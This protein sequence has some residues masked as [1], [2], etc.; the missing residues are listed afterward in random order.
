MQYRVHGTASSRL[1]LISSPQERH[2]PK[3]PSRTRL[4]ASSTSWSNCFSFVL[5][6]NKKS[7]V[8]VLAARSIT[9]GAT[10]SSM[11]RPDCCFWV[12]LRRSSCWR[13]SSRSPNC[14]SRFLS[15]V[16]AKSCDYSAAKS[17]DYS[18]E[19]VWRLPMWARGNTSSFSPRFPL[20]S[21]QH[22]CQVRQSL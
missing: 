20:R 11:V 21:G 9:S 8:Y 19:A 13:V 18:A 1:E 5:C 22:L 12:T 10:A 16:Q 3:L 7:F 4:S 17:Y 6:R 15:I 14:C 2:R